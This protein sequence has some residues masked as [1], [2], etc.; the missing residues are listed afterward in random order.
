M[1][2]PRRLCFTETAP[3]GRQLN[4]TA[5]KV[6]FNKT[7]WTL[8]LDFPSGRTV[9]QNYFASDVP[10][11]EAL[12]RWMQDHHNEF[13]NDRREVGSIPSNVGGYGSVSVP[14]GAR[15]TNFRITPARER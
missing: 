11:G 6:P 14:D 8:K 15:Q 3:D 9:T 4:A 7:Q 10:V 5:E 13:L 1:S 2:D 12:A